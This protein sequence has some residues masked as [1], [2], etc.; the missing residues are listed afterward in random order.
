MPSPGYN[1]RYVP[2]H[3]GRQRNNCQQAQE[4]EQEMLESGVFTFIYGHYGM[5]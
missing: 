3:V 5:Q 4:V 2:V 1:W